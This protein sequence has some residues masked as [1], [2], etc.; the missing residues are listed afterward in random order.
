MWVNATDERAHPVTTGSEPDWAVTLAEKLVASDAELPETLSGDEALALAWA[1]KERISV[2]WRSDPVDVP[3]VEHALNTM[4]ERLHSRAGGVATFQPDFT[5]VCEWIYGIADITQGRMSESVAHFSTAASL[6]NES[7]DAQHAAE[8]QVPKVMALSLLGLH[9]EAIATAT[10]TYE[11]LL[12]LGD[13]HAAGKVSLNLGNLYCHRKNYAAALPHYHEAVRLFGQIGETQLSAV[14]EI[15][16]ADA[17]ASTGDFKKAL[18]MYILARTHAR[19]H[20]LPVLDAVAEESQA[21]VYLARGEFRDALAGL[22]NCRRIYARL[23]MPQNLATAE[24]QLADAYLE[25]RLLPEALGLF[26]AAVTH[27]ESL[28][29]PVETAWALTQRGRTLAALERPAED[30]ADSLRRAWDLFA[31]QQVS[32]GQATVLMARAELALTSD[33][34]ATA[35]ML[36]R[37]A[38]ASYLECALLPGQ[39]RANALQAQAL[40]QCGE[41]EAASALFE[42]TAS[43]ARALQL[44]SV[45][46]DCQVGL[47]QIA[48]ARGDS[49]SAERIFE[50]AIAAFEDQRSALP[51]DDI[52]NAFLV[53]HLRPYE[54]L[55]RI[56]LAVHERQ[57]SSETASRVLTRLEQFRARVLGERLGEPGAHETAT[58]ADTSEQNLRTRLSW[59]Y[60]RTQKL[61]DEG[62]DTLSLIG[63][64]RNA[65]RDLLESARRRRLTGHTNPLT[66]DGAKLD[67]SQLQA[68]LG[69]DDALVEYGVIDD[70]LFACVVTRSEVTLKRH[71]A[72]WTAVLAAVRTA[73]FQIETMRY[74][75]G[76]VDRHLDLLT[77][78]SRIAMIRVHDLIWA[79]LSVLLAGCSNVLVVPHEQLG[80]IQFAALHDGTHHLAQSLNLSIVPSAKIALH[81]LTHLPVACERV[82]VLGESS[83]LPHAAEEARAV[84]ALFANATV[85]ADAGADAPSLRA[86]SPNADVLHL[87]CHGEFRSDNPMFSALHLADGPFTVQDAES[88]HLRQGI[89]VLSACETG[90]AAYSRGDEMIGLVRAF[91]LAGAARV[92]ASMWPVDDAVTVKFMTAFYQ[93]LRDGRPPSRALRDAQLELMATYPHPFHWAAFTLYGGW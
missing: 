87:A 64:T 73:R 7:G 8:T 27:F 32:A 55:L 72:P 15:G 83:R 9:A 71:L 86:S 75:I 58:D 35:V 79:P 29:M 92:V 76:A 31:T 34:P 1:L 78:R 49:A 14:S 23:G 19:Q 16:I 61:A 47:G 33:D 51:G 10:Q 53:D 30:V 46:I 67:I 89:V 5:A 52:R 44:L 57:P 13:L 68:L 63:E 59:L 2:A 17:S 60:R 38:A 36:A 65:E 81:G 66:P 41:T 54:A 21:L 3:R 56:A 43:Q 77:G 26:D 6:F 40:L 62:E 4:I 45:D 11:T 82:V 39:A 20:N 12:V 90:V 25:L 50:I 28:A 18:E 70:E 37:D 24:K 93:S 69:N 84:A 85:L 88:L 74:G 42:Q 48:L 22:E 91:M 80:A